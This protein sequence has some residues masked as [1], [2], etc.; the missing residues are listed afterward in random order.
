MLHSTQLLLPGLSCPGD[1]GVSAS[2][3]P[4]VSLALLGRFDPAADAR[5]AAGFAAVTLETQSKM[6]RFP[7]GNQRRGGVAWTRIFAGVTLA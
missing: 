3:T 2:Q 5:F 6:F 1:S 4:G 7:V